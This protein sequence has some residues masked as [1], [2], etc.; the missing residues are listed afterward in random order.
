MRLVLAA[1][2][3]T[4]V[5]GCMYDARPV[6]DDTG[7]DTPPTPYYLDCADAL[8]QGE[9]T[10]G[11]YTIDPDGAGAFDVYCDQTYDGGGWTLVM[12][13]DGAQG[14]FRFDSPYWST[15]ALLNPA[16]ADHDGVE[17]KLPSFSRVAAD[18]VMIETATGRVAINPGGQEPLFGH[19]NGTA[20]IAAPAGRSAWQ[21]LVPGSDL[22][23]QEC[24]WIEGTN[25]GDDDYAARVGLLAFDGDREESQWQCSTRLDGSI[26][27]GLATTDSCDNGPD[28]SI[29]AGNIND[30]CAM[31]V[32]AYVYV[33]D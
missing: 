5:A 6:G 3:A 30:G 18:D 15:D 25:I 20:E 19:V 9:T 24:P 1:L 8:A 16:D 29:S 27:V 2:L 21:A 23:P 13:I 14:T 26:G 31:P 11:V 4:V 17:A 22:P 12:K 7:D 10:D 32:F 33:R 28:S